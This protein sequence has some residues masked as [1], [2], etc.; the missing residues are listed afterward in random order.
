MNNLDFIEI[1][2]R[3]RMMQALEMRR[4]FDAFGH[5]LAEGVRRLAHSLHLNT[6]SHA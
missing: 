3:A 4:L 1:E 6:K 2:Q 5:A